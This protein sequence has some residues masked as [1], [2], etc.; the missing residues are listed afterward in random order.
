[1]H[2]NGPLR[3]DILEDLY[4]VLRGAVDGRHEVARLVSS[5][6]G[7]TSVLQPESCTLPNGNEG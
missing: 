3:L 4:A 7:S 1:M 5:E 6:I 2:P